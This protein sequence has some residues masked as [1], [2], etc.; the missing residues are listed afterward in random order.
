MLHIGTG[1]PGQTAEW[2]SC[3]PVVVS[4]AGPFALNDDFWI[5]KLDEQLA[6][7]IQ[8]ACDP[9]HYG[10]NNDQTD[11]HLYAFV[12][13]VSEVE[14]SQYEGM[15][16]LHAVVAL[17]RLIHPTSTGDRYCAWILRYDSPESPIRAVQYRGIDFA[18]LNWPLSMV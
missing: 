18:T 3:P 13:R 16:E 11:R 1:L 2:E 6:I 4:G 12:R 9:P 14:T 10:I 8:A 7:H 15:D 17:S 5:E